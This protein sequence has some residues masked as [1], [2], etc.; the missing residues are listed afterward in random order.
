QI[1]NTARENATHAVAAETRPLLAAL[2]TQM[3]EAAEKSV[4]AAVA[5]HLEK[6][7]QETLQRME[8][9]RETG[10]AAMLEK[11]SAELDL[12]LSEARRQMENQLAKVERTR[13]SEFDQQI[14]NQV[15]AAIQKLEDL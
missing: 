15:Q 10:M 11:L 14:Q 13:R 8:R 7:Q 4:A 9:E 12:R 2:Q 3:N 5:S 1:Q 6:S